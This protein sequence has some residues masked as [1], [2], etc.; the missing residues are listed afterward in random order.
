MWNYSKDAY[1][2]DFFE[3]QLSGDLMGASSNNSLLKKQKLLIKQVR[4][5]NP[6]F[7]ISFSNF[8]NFQAFIGGCFCN[9][10]TYGGFRSSAA[11]MLD[12]LSLKKILSLIFPFRI[13]SNS[14]VAIDE[15]KQIWWLKHV[16]FKH[17]P[18]FIDLVQFLGSDPDSQKEFHSISVGSLLP[19]KRLNRLFDLILEMK[20]Y[21]PNI[22]H[23]HLGDGP[24]MNEYRKKI[25]VLELSE[26]I[27]FLGKTKAVREHLSK[28]KV[29][30][31]FSDFEGTPNVV[32]EAMA[33]GLP[34]ISTNC[35]DVATYLK[36]NE[37]GFVIPRAEAYDPKLFLEKYHHLLGNESERRN[38][39]Q[40]SLAIIENYNLERMA[41]TFLKLIGLN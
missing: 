22:K 16:R 11:Y 21:I 10:K 4:K 5:S 19:G 38:K 20:K 9:A 29:F 40:N 36:D 37:N 26:H 14:K 41:F 8:T 18:N 24:L 12:S 23:I 33:V 3:E 27:S 39:G 17:F 35:G 31:H 13:I 32:L 2:F 34:V 1:Y 6:A 7:I 30:V 25:K 15:L 28:S